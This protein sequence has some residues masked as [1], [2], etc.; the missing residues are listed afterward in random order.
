M[1]YSHFVWT[2][3]DEESVTYDFYASEDAAMYAALEA[4]RA[5]YGGTIPTEVLENYCGSPHEDDFFVYLC[6]HKDVLHDF[7]LAVNFQVVRD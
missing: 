3:L 1:K 7:G 6:E 4:I 2:L 5:S